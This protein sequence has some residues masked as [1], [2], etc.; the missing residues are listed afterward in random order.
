[1]LSS[2][3]HLSFAKFIISVG[4]CLMHVI[5]RLRYSKLISLSIP[6]GNSVG[7][8]VAEKFR[9]LMRGMNWKNPLGN[10]FSSVHSLTNRVWRLEHC[11]VSGSFSIFLPH[12]GI[13][14]AS[15]Q[16]VTLPV[17]TNR[18]DSDVARLRRIKKT[19]KRN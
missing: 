4:N 16:M 10:V 13:L 19:N 5:E 1:M 11:G 7:L 17:S 15:F 18:K 3:R 14:S 6:A 2:S 12:N 9:T 8:W